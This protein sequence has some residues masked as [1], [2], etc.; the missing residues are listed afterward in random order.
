MSLLKTEEPLLKVDNLTVTFPTAKGPVD[1]VKNFN[2]EMGKEKIGIVGESG[3]GK[4]MTA[5]AILGLLPQ[6][7]SMKA[8]SLSLQ[9]TSLLDLS[10][11]QWRQVRGKAITMV[12]QD[13]KFS[14]N[15][16][17]TI[18]RQLLETWKL[19]HK[20]N[21]Q[22]AQ[23]A[24]Y[25][26]LSEVAIRDP[27]RVLSCYPHQ[28]SGG[29]G[30]RVMIAMMLLPQP[31]ILIADEATSALDVT[32]QKQVLELLNKSVQAHD[33]GLILISH[34]LHLVAEF[35]D[36][37]IVMYRGG[38]VETLLASDL[39]QAQHPYTQGLLACL[40]SYQKRGQPLSTLKRDPA[41]EQ[42][43]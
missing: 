35:C 18:E 21:K 22:D 24:I 41:W 3:S 15:P 17:I 33:S 8:K 26:A 13:P 36:R 25:E 29:M 20:G 40:P 9:G 31:S 39:H 16:V 28:L 43:A 19:H 6:A 10:S 27:E 30:Q 14:L 34:D 7:A 2:L 1:V 37:I 11:R 5:R 42:Q 23:Q 38:I 4:S 12:M 32:V